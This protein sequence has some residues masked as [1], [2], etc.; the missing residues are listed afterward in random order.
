MRLDRTFNWQ[1]SSEVFWLPD[2]RAPRAALRT[3]TLCANQA[4]ALSAPDV[5]G[6]EQVL[7]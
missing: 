2:A 4:P 7:A 5:V 3:L 6:R 1:V